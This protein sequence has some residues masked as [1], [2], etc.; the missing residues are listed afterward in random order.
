MAAGDSQIGGGPKPA[1]ELDDKTKAI[2]K[3]PEIIP[4]SGIDFIGYKPEYG[5][6]EVKPIINP[7]HIGGSGSDRAL[8]VSALYE[9][10]N[11]I[12]S[13]VQPFGD[14]PTQGQI[15][16]N[17]VNLNLNLPGKFGMMLQGPA[18]DQNASGTTIYV[19]NYLDALASG[20]GLDSS[21]PFVQGWHD[22][23][24][25]AVKGQDGNTGLRIVVPQDKTGGLQNIVLGGD[26]DQNET[27][28]VPTILINNT[29]TLVTKDIDTVLMVG[30]G[31]LRVSNS[32]STPS[33]GHSQGIIKGTAVAGD[34]FNQT[35]K[36]G[37]GNDT[38]TGGGGTDFL[39]G[40]A[41]DDRFYFGLNGN[42]VIT[43]F[44]FKEGEHDQIVF[45]KDI[46]LKILANDLTVTLND[47]S[48]GGYNIADININGNHLILVGLKAGDLTQEMIDFDV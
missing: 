15:F 25:N 18:T 37:D 40:G 6:G 32:A 28:L 35:I 48:V 41:G 5:Q 38:L 7:A 39:G 24:Y 34:T 42:T 17:N 13:I 11:E 45:N 31:N 10:A 36:G 21:S 9:N 4:P 8:Y 30:S 26:P 29:N 1:D 46:I 3:N 43:D 22:M 19:N 20:L 27:L 12:K 2:L 33:A 47:I 44:T 14:K 16:D 23:T